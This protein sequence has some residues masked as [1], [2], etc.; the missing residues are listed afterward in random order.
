MAEQNRLNDKVLIDV[1]NLIKMHKEGLLGGQIM[2]EDANPN[3]S[4]GSMEN[5][6]YF[7]LPMALNY[8]RN[9]YLLWSAAKQTYMDE[10]TRPI[11]NP[12]SVVNMTDEEL[13]SRL[14]K[15]KVALQPVRHM[16]IWR[17]LCQTIC[18]SFDGD[19]RNLFEINKWHIPAVLDYVRKKNKK[20]FP[21]LSGPKICNYW[22]YVIGNYTDAALSGREGLTIAP[23]THV[24][25][26]TVKLGLVD[27]DLMNSP[28]IQNIVNDAWDDLLE[29]T[30]LVPIDIHTPLWLWSRNGF[31]DI[32][33]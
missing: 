31:R 11:F 9:S 18:A 28:D 5:Y 1:Y 13:R 12:N 10:N 7:T 4:K 23:D 2:P 15:Y 21:Y 30:D 33:G 22:L 20:D 19:I 3:L 6:H 27:K 17:R 16:E 26:A 25:Q 24:I 14:T 8:Q 29:G 32:I